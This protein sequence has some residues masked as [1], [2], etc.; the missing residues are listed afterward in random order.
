MI[1]RKIVSENLYNEKK[2]HF[3]P[4]I[5]QSINF[6]KVKEEKKKVISLTFI[7]IIFL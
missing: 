5:F 3:S 7:I 1:F 2:K 4:T 6:E